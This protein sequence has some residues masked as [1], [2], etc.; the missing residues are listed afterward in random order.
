MKTKIHRLFGLKI[1]KVLILTALFA[2]CGLA[3]VPA[4]MAGDNDYLCAQLNRIRAEENMPGLAP[5]LIVPE[6]L[7]PQ[8]APQPFRLILCANGVREWGGSQQIND[9]AQFGLGSISKPV[10]GLMIARFIASESQKTNPRLTWN[11]RLEDFFNT[12]NLPGSNRCYDQRTVSDLMAHT[13]GFR[14]V[15]LG[16]P[17]DQWMS[18]EPDPVKRRQMFVEA[19]IKD[20][21]KVTC[22][23][24]NGHILTQLAEN[25]S[26]GSVIATHM[27]EI[28][29]GQSWE[30]LMFTPLPLTNK[31]GLRLNDYSV[32]LQYVP[33]I[34]TTSMEFRVCT[35]AP[36]KT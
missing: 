32:P 34:C 31:P 27:V 28:I 22:I 9:S 18:L 14:D 12:R 29:T 6:P 33:G 19:A 2:G 30:E 13:A 3:T 5:G 11:T 23:D 25:Y 21:P 10:T 16:E 15:P 1:V 26:G 36:F 7:Y 35:A 8:Y 20:P 4:A 17:G 24:P